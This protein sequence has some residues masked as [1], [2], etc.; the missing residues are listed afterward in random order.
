MNYLL[1]E[2]ML[3]LYSPIVNTCTDVHP[4]YWPAI[5]VFILLA[6]VTV[7][8]MLIGVL[9]EVVR[10]VAATEKEGMT[11]IHVTHQLKQVM[12]QFQ[13]GSDLS[14]ARE[15]GSMKRSSIFGKKIT[16][17]NEN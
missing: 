12:A 14:N 8:N 11:V 5:M 13:S 3:P 10:T 9:V 16:S 6:S 2:G 15:E 4:A 17:D 7:M 1:L